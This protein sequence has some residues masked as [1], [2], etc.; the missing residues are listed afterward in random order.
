MKIEITKKVEMGEKILPVK[1]EET[2]TNVESRKF[3]ETIE[4]K[5][6]EYVINI[7]KNGLFGK[8]Q[9]PQGAG[10][11]LVNAFKAGAKFAQQWIN[12][13]DEAQK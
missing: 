1:P 10:V 2:V 4:E 8:L 9:N 3:V 11:E 7:S 13:N 6:I 12:V 5:A